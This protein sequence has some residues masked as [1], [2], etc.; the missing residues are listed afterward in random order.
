MKPPPGEASG[1]APSSTRTASKEHGAFRGAAPGTAGTV[2]DPPRANL[3]NHE[4]A[5]GLLT[6]ERDAAKVFVEVAEDAGTGEGF[7]AEDGEDPAESLAVQVRR[8]LR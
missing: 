6:E 2:G 4:E 1:T 3:E 8:D 7:P 5:R